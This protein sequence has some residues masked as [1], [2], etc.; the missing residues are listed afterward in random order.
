MAKMTPLLI[1]LEPELV[2]RIDDLRGDVPRAAFVRRR[3]AE[4]CAGPLVVINN[5]PTETVT[6]S[7]VGTKTLTVRS[8]EP[9]ARVAKA[10]RPT[11]LKG[12]WKAP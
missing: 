6:V 7:S 2:A 11:R 1:R 10:A 4:A 5:D 12:E 9:S 8:A 3:L